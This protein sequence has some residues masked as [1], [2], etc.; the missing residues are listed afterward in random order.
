MI[1][2]ALAQAIKLDTDDSFFGSNPIAK[3][4]IVDGP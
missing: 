4:I 2:D 3:K 1:D